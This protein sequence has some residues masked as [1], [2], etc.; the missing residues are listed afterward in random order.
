[1][2]MHHK[3]FTLRRR[4]VVCFVWPSLNIKWPSFLI[5]AWV[6]LKHSQ[7]F[8]NKFLFSRNFTGRSS[9]SIQ[10]VCRNFKGYRSMHE[11]T[12]RKY[13]KKTLLLQLWF[14]RKKKGRFVFIF[15]SLHWFLFLFVYLLLLVVASWQK[16]AGWERDMTSDAFL[17]SHIVN[18][19]YLNQ[20]VKVKTDML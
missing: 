11:A 6:T 9:K 3:L 13:K 7:E 2:S 10:P 8:K 5:A 20:D 18:V 12:L 17:I 19:V 14:L 1:M 16:R 15:L 4:R